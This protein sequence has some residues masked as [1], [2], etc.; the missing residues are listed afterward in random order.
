[1]DVRQLV[2]RGYAL[3]G[4]PDTV[5]QKFTAYQQELGFGCFSGIFQFGSLGHEDFLG[6]LHL[7]AD[8]VMPAVRDLG[9]ADDV[10]VRPAG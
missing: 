6:S 4:S 2:E 8:K 3:V 7:F 5:R 10:P 1:V 9:Q